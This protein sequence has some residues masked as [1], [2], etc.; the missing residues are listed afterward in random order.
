VSG[1]IVNLFVGNTE[2]VAKKI[3]AITGSELF[4]IETVKVYP[5]DYTETTNIAMVEKKGN[6]RPEL[7]ETVDNMDSYD[8]VYLGYPNWWG[9]FP[10]QYLHFWNRM[11][12]QERPLFHFVLTKGAEWGTVNATLNNFVLMQRC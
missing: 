11:I 8:V 3:Q 9:T 6:S 1:T 12:F 2:V 10:W 7:T 4:E 5:E